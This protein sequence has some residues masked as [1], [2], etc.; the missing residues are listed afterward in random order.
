MVTNKTKTTDSLPS[1]HYGEPAHQ[2]GAGQ[3]N[4]PPFRSVRLLAILRMALLR[5]N[6]ALRNLFPRCGSFIKLTMQAQTII[7]R[8]LV[9]REKR[10]IMN[11]QCRSAPC[12]T[13]KQGKITK[14]MQ[15]RIKRTCA[16]VVNQIHPTLPLKQIFYPLK[17]SRRRT[18]KKIGGGGF[19]AKPMKRETEPG[20]RHRYKT[21]G[22]RR[23]ERFMEM[24]IGID[25]ERWKCKKCAPY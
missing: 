14:T 13:I 17:S 24:I 18:H 2:L 21:C 1:L 3:Q 8:L 10:N 11:S 16:R 9:R 6:G 23:L 5:R 22:K 19:A 20:N 12:S 25:L 7:T 15:N 4:H